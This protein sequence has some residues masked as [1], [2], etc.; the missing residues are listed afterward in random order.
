MKKCFPARI[1][2]DSIL[3]FTMLE[4]VPRSWMEKELTN[5]IWT[6]RSINV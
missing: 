1:T 2:V 6:I 4:I 3:M 5:H